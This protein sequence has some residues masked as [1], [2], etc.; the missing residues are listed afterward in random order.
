MTGYEGDTGRRPSPASDSKDSALTVDLVSPRE[1]S[2]VRDRL[3]EWL[4]ANARHV[5][6]D[7]PTHGSADFGS[8][9][10]YRMLGATS[11][12]SAQLPFKLSWQIT[13]VSE[14]S[15]IGLRMQSNEG[16]YL[17]RTSYHYAAYDERFAGLS[18]ELGELLN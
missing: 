2:E 7:G 12:G 3:E 17:L 10:V 15:R 9:F 16:K 1:P 14:G 11:L 5:I 18:A 6:A 4:K 13:P 8:R